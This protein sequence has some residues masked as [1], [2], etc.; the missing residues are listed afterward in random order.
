MQRREGENTLLLYLEE[1]KE[2]ITGSLFIVK[3]KLAQKI[4]DNVTALPPFL[5]PQEVTP[6]IDLI[7]KTMYHI[8]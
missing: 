4:Y 2:G 3:H 7:L 1:S 5:T 6:T 8:R